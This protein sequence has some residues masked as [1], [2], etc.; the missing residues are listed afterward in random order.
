MYPFDFVLL[1]VRLL[2][3]NSSP[4]ISN[5]SLVAFADS[6]IFVTLF[7]SFVENFV[8]NS[9]SNVFTLLAASVLIFG[10]FIFTF[11]SIAL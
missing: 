8:L 5:T 3:E 10:S 1:P 7:E 11:K 4:G 2:Y 6:T 9:A